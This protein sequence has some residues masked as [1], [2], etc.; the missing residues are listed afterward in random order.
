MPDYDF[1]VVG[2]S[3]LDIVA[4]TSSVERID[5]GRKVVERLV[6]I[7]FASKT[8]L[9]SLELHPGGSASNSAIM[10][11][12][13]G[14]SVYLLSAV[15]RDE[16]G[17][18]VLADLKRNG[19]NTATVR[20]LGNSSTGVGISILSSGG[21]KSSLVYRGANSRLGS[22]DVSEAEI[23]G[24]K[25]V[26]ITSLVSEKNYGLFRKVLA[27]A[28]KHGRQA[29]FAPSIT[30]LHRWMPELKKLKPHFDM[31]IMNY[32]EGRHYTGKS[33]V[34]EILDL[35]PGKVAVVTKDAEGAYAVERNGGSRRYAHIP[36]VPVRVVDTTGAGDAFGG[37]FAST[38]CSSRSLPEALKT[39]VA[40]AALKLTHKGAH[41]SL[42]RA[43]LDAFM[44][45]NSSRMAVRRF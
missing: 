5:I 6:C 42:K 31:V 25:A 26:F 34:K 18:S 14:S 8:E 38:Y 45:K 9:E 11:K 3:T 36:A 22:G 16:F 12:T 23:K 33:G 2:S 7:P 10:M 43:V 41:F 27:L 15:G 44:R 39:A 21:E 1:L 37:A 30:M 19:I 20:V 32:E 13:L 4:K 28:K 40:A 35:L 17:R 29:I 24:A